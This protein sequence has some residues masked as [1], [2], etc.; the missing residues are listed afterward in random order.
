IFSFFSFSLQFFILL[1][2]Y[3]IFYWINHYILISKIFKQKGLIFYGFGFAATLF[4]LFPIA[5]EIISWLPMVQRH[6][7]HPSGYELPFS[8]L[9]FIIPFFG[10]LASTPIILVAQWSKQNNEII[11]L[12]KEKSNTELRLLKQQINPHFFFNTL[13]NLYALSLTKDKKTPEVILQLSELMR[14]V[15]KKGQEDRVALKEEVKYIEDYIWLQRIRL[16][17]QLDFVFE[18]E[19]ENEELMIPPLL[20]INLVENAF[21]HGIEPAEGN[22]HLYLHLK[23]KNNRLFFTCKNSFE[24]QALSGNGTG[25]SN[26]KRRL[27][28]RFPQK[29]EL[30]NK[31]EANVYHAALNLIL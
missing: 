11:N 2:V 9:H 15:I 4:L 30:I 17:K 18:K 14:Y 28:L 1:F 23:T 16:H 24:E 20:F 10:M 31:K 3:Y 8:G 26:L 5:A 21:K 7:V 25:L 22:C 6:N 27:A 29:H 13:N 19:I 12:E